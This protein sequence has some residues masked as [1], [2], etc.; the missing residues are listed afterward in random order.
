MYNNNIY[1]YIYIYIY[2]YYKEYEAIIL[3]YKVIILFIYT[4]L[5]TPS[6]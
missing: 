4:D 1:I 6:E 2:Y 5:P 3:L